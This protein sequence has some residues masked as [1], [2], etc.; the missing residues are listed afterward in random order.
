MQ[1][2]NFRR[3]INKYIKYL[4]FWPE[5]MMNFRAI[6]GRCSVNVLLCFHKDPIHPLYEYMGI[7]FYR[8]A[9]FAPWDLRFFTEKQRLTYGNFGPS[10]I[11]QWSSWNWTWGR[12]KTQPG[13]GWH[14][15]WNSTNFMGIF[16]RYPPPGWQPIAGL[17]KGVLISPSCLNKAQN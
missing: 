11:I 7:P 1:V 13:K 12:T 9:F 17:S 15:S 5:N 2:P 16:K 3:E 10:A 8:K 14:L 6:L 4:C